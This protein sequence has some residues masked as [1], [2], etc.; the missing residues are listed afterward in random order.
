VPGDS[1]KLLGN[2]AL[3]DARGNI[4]NMS[5]FVPVGGPKEVVNVDISVKGAGFASGNT[6]INPQPVKIP[7]SVVPGAVLVPNPICLDCKD[8]KWK[9]LDPARPG[10]FP[11]GP[12]IVVST[13]GPFR[14]DLNFYTNLGEFV[15]SA[16]GE[17][18]ELML[19]DLPLDSTGRKVV[20]LMWYPVSQNGHQAG[21]GAYIAKGR[22]IIP[23]GTLQG[24]QGEPIS[25]VGRVNNVA[26]LLGY[27][28]KGI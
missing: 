1:I 3:I 11:Q 23:S 26:I 10:A 17:V 7:V 19:Q 22:F 15:N 16:K 4:S 20:S 28:R 21:T 5:Y 24:G 2:P 18:T 9:S 14:F 13:K 8:P 27:L 25:V 12:L 6:L